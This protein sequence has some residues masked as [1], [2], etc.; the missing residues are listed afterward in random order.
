MLVSSAET[1]CDRIRGRAAGADG[2]LSKPV[3][4]Q[5]LVERVR[6]L[7]R[8]G[9]LARDQHTPGRQAEPR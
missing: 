5:E 9:G 4:R 3:R 1:G 2:F 8:A 6:S 7:V